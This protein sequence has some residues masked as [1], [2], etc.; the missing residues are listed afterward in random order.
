VAAIAD[1][2]NIP[3]PERG[4]AKIQTFWFVV[5]QLVS[6]VFN[7]SIYAGSTVAP[8]SVGVLKAQRP[9]EDETEGER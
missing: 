3:Y 6:V 4:R 9:W 5:A 8:V 7:S 2:G 1:A